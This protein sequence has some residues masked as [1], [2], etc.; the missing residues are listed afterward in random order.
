MLDVVLFAS[1]VVFSALAL[2]KSWHRSVARTVSRR[3]SWWPTSERAWLGLQAGQA[4]TPI[5][6]G[7]GG[8]GVI[9]AG[10][11]SD[12]AFVAFVVITLLQGTVFLLG[13]PSFLMPPAFRGSFRGWFRT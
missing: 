8:V 13:F 4:L 12:V 11:V 10:T 7:T 9:A 5:W 1:L 3:P 6:F 2:V